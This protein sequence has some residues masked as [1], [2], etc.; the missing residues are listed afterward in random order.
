MRQKKVQFIALFLFSVIIFFSTSQLTFAQASD[1]LT[2]PA[3]PFVDIPFLQNIT[4]AILAGIIA[5]ASGYVL[6][7]ISKKSSSK[8]LSYNL[9]IETGLVNVEKTVKEKV[10][11][12]YEDKEIANLS[13]I[14]ID[15]ENTGSSIVKSQEIRFEFLQ[16]TKILNFYFDPQPQPE[17]KVEE[18]NDPNLKEFE[19]K[20]RIGHIEKEGKL[21]VRF[22]VTSN[23]E[24][25]PTLHPYNENGDVELVSR[26]ATKILSQREQVVKFI[27]LLIMYFVIPPAFLIVSPIR[28][29]IPIAALIRLGLLVPLFSSI[30][31][32]SEVVGELVFKWLNFEEKDKQSLSLLQGAIIEGEIT[33]GEITQ[34]MRK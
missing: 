4:L 8:R 9:D 24:V 1:P 33:V 32:F 13:N 29:P 25:K 31:P 5:F 26:V 11:V 14:N 6:A 3:K 22:V 18:I 10:K 23:S 2:S 21:G 34:E 15:I 7:G 28:E 17:M 12:L 27:S 16:G 19:R 30:V 20:C